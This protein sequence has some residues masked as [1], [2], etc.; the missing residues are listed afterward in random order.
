MALTGS[1]PAENPGEES[2]VHPPVSPRVRRAFWWL[3][4]LAPGIGARWATELWC[5]VP[6]VDLSTKMPPGLPPSTPLEAFWNGHRVAGESW[7]EGPTVYL[8]HGWGGCRAHMAVFV[9]PLVA[10]GHR[11][12][13][14]DLPSHN[15]S[16]PGALA[17]GRSTIVECAEAVQAVVRTHGPARAIVGHSLGAK[18]AALAV[19][20]GTSAERLVFL[21]PM[22]GFSWYLDVFT[23]RHGFG[24]RIRDR[25]HRR[26]SRRIGM[27]LLDTDIATLAVRAG[28]RPLMLVHDPD[29]P[30][31]LHSASEE[32]VDAWPGARL[33]T[34]RGLGR[35]AHYRILR[36]RPAILA[37]V[38]F[39]GPA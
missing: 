8:V 31:S 19:A 22:G 6:D 36:H 27:Q 29:D 38:D 34:T 23:E 10:A 32:I 1:Q 15:G 13:A 26:L 21:A 14:F 16:E 5:T 12:I 18:A 7:G 11:V 33:E 20:R 17:P 35:L 3:E 37:G 25:M 2:G 28:G 30:D 9:K 24:R 4:R 39:I